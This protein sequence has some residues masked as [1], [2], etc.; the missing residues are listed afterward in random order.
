MAN[1]KQRKVSIEW[2]KAAL[3]EEAAS[4]HELEEGGSEKD[5]ALGAVEAQARSKEDEL[6]E[7]ILDEGEA[8]E[9]QRA[10]L[11]KVTANE[12]ARVQASRLDPSRIH[13][14]PHT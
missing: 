10:A 3:F 4:L 1:V 7:T 5:E 9:T 2:D 13:L 14:T 8:Y 6:N 12:K 11:A